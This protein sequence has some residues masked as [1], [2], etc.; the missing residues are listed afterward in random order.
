MDNRTAE[1]W[2][3]PIP[4]DAQKRY[5]AHTGR[6]DAPREIPEGEVDPR[7]LKGL[8]RLDYV[9]NYRNAKGEPLKAEDRMRYTADP[10]LEV[11]LPPTQEEI[12]AA[13]A[14]M[15]AQRRKYSGQ[16]VE[17]PKKDDGDEAGKSGGS[18]PGEGQA[19]GKGKNP[20]STETRRPLTKK[21]DPIP[22]KTE[23]RGIIPGSEIALTGKA[24]PYKH[25]TVEE[26][27]KAVEQSK[28]YTEE[29]ERKE[30]EE[31]ERKIK[32]SNVSQAL[33]DRLA[34]QAES[35]KKM[36]APKSPSAPSGGPPSEP[37]PSQS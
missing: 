21:P 15:E 12:V 23:L 14:E 24:E 19:A 33:R 37:G 27:L 3:T 10:E 34:A 22:A 25:V 4:S 1:K 35:I 2:G 9:K 11:P 18:A 28:E 30:A 36:Q 31:K 26:N 13:E 17:Q 32:S 7:T 6:G 29:L 16:P 8:A 5:E 20:G